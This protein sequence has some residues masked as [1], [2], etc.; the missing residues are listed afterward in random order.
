MREDIKSI[1]KTSKGRYGYR[2][3]YKGLRNKGL[4]NSKS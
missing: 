1:V 3:V 4:F 2:R